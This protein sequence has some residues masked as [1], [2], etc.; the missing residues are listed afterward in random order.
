MRKLHWE[1]YKKLY[2]IRRAEESIR[3]RYSQD[4]MKTPMHMSMGEEAIVVGVLEAA[5][6]KSQVFG[7]YRSHALYLAKTGETDNFF[8]EMYGKA[9]GAAKGKAG[10]MH[11]ALP[12]AGMMMTSA[13]VG[14]TIPVAVGAALAAAYK[15]S[16]ALTVSFFGDGAVNEGVFWESMN[17]ACVKK[18]PILFVCEDNDLAIHSRVRERSGHKP[19]SEVVSTFYCHAAAS[20]TTDVYE[21]YEITKKMAAGMRRSHMPGFLH[22]KYYRYLEHVGVGEDFESGYRSK[23]EQLPWLKRD[24][25][26]VQRERLL[27]L[28]AK[29]SRI[30]ALEK[31]IDK[32][33][34]KSIGKAQKAPFAKTSEAFA[35]VYA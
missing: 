5:G 23:K 3:E 16:G 10:S 1:L 24:P 15:K 22:F 14:T 27:K 32:Q 11:V 13:V 29:E 34:E 18:L 31:N 26:K 21:I 19:I 6:E 17:F 30:R 8:A 7:T 4:E 35:N 25:V 33:I 12:G 2:L 28:G 9:T 20:S